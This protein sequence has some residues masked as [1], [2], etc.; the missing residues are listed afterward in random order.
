MQ[1]EAA[2]LG[3]QVRDVMDEFTSRLFGAN[4]KA[5]RLTTRFAILDVPFAAVRR[6]VGA[7][8]APPPKIDRHIATA[9][10]AI[11]EQPAAGARKRGG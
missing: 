3:Q 8:E 4:T 2:R 1:D 6:Y 9:V 7:N 10:N 11:L 5:T